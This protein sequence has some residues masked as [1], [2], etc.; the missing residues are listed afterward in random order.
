MPVA[1]S[2]KVVNGAGSPETLVSKAELA[3]KEGAANG[4]GT[5]DGQS[6][7]RGRIVVWGRAIGL[8]ARATRLRRGTSGQQKQKS[9]S[10]YATHISPDPVRLQS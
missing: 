7:R 1:L 2:V 4:L 9:K 8:R 3:A 10:G 6:L 5:L